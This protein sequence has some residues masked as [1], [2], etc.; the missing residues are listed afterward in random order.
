[1]VD[2][3]AA[4]CE[5]TFLLLVSELPDINGLVTTEEDAPSL[6]RRLDVADGNASYGYLHVGRVE[7]DSPATVRRARGGQTNEQDLCMGCDNQ[8]V[9]NRVYEDALARLDKLDG[10]DGIGLV[11]EAD[12]FRVRMCVVPKVERRVDHDE[13][14]VELGK[15]TQMCRDLGQVRLFE[16]LLGDIIVATALE[17]LPGRVEGSIVII[18]D[19][20]ADIV[21]KGWVL[22]LTLKGFVD[23]AR[24]AFDRSEGVLRGGNR[25]LCRRIA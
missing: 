21:V 25:S 17:G 20:L 16:D 24:C 12:E 3:G 19:A 4:V 23:G 2:L 10:R 15:E 9:G 13:G 5:P 22:G 14:V 7:L 1:M 6:V 18:G 11:F 8:Q